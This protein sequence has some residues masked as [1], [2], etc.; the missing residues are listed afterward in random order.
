M[1]ST[2]LIETSADAYKVRTK[3][4]GPSGPDEA[5][6]KR[7]PPVGGGLVVREGAGSAADS[8]DLAAAQRAGALERRLAVLH[9]DLLGVLDFDLLLV[10]DAI[11][12][13]HGAPPHPLD[14]SRDPMSRI[15][16]LS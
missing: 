8:E 6:V 15:R 1:K 3:A 2:D 5:D 10:L 13:G 9:R 12:F 16:E 4:P 7:P 11:G 14:A